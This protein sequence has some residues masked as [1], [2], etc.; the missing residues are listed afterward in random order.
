[1]TAGAVASFGRIL[2]V[3]GAVILITG[4]VMILGPRIPILGNLPGD[5][6]IERENAT[7]FIPLGTMLVVSVAASLILALLNRR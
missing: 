1:M 4:L 6:R 3:V 2:V 5:I 7:I